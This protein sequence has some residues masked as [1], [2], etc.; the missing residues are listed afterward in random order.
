MSK[1][2][3]CSAVIAE[4]IVR[5]MRSAGESWS[6]FSLF[7]AMCLAM[8]T[9]L[10]GWFITL[11][12]SIE[13]MSIAWPAL[14]ALS[15]FALF[16][17]VLWSRTHSILFGEIG[18]VYMGLALIYTVTP[19]VKFILLNADI[20]ITFDQLGFSVLKP[21]AAELGVHFWRHVLF[22]TAVGLGY[23]LLRGRKPIKCIPQGKTQPG[24]G[25]L[26]PLLLIIIG[27]CIV[28]TVLLS[29][30]VKSYIDHYRRYDQLSGL[31]LFLVHACLLVKSGL[32]FVLFP[33]LFLQY[34][35]YKRL[36]FV[37]VPLVSIYEIIYSHGARIM[38]GVL[39]IACIVLYSFRVKAFGI[40]RGLILFFLAVF[41][42]WL[43]GQ[44]RMLNPLNDGFGKVWAKMKKDVFPNTSPKSLVT[45]DVEH[46]QNL[47]F[48]RFGQGVYF[49][50]AFRGDWV[51]IASEGRRVAVTDIDGDEI[52]DPILIGG[53]GNEIF[54]YYSSVKR[55]VRM[56]KGASDIATGDINGDGRADLLASFPGKGVFSC[57]PVTGTWTRIAS[58][59]VRL[60]A[61]DIDGDGI[62]DLIGIW[63]DQNGVFVRYSGTGKWERIASAAMDVAAGDVDCDGR[64]DIVATWPD[65]GV[66]YRKAKEGAWVRLASY[67]STVAVGLWDGD[68]L[69]DLVAVY[70]RLGKICILK[71]TTQAWSHMSL[72][73][74]DI[75]FGRLRKSPWLSIQKE[76]E[77]LWEHAAFDSVVGQHYDL[78]FRD[79][80][81]AHE[82]VIKLAS[83]NFLHRIGKHDLQPAQGLAVPPDHLV[84]NG[85]KSK[86]KVVPRLYFGEEDSVFCSGFHLY[87]ERNLSRLPPRQW[88]LH[89]DDIF[90]PVPFIDH[91]THN[92]I[93][94]YARHYFPDRVVPP[95]TFGVIA[96]SAVLGGEWDL[97]LRGLLNGILF[98]LVTAWFSN[99][100]K[101][102]WALIVY[103]FMHVTAI[104]VLKYS[105]F[106]Q[107]APLIRS[108]LPA[109]L[110]V[111]LVFKQQKMVLKE[112]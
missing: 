82:D 95:T 53:E 2:D 92:P 67:A 105:V 96:Q 108:I 10:S 25:I 22:M 7:W 68:A 29:A 32:Y 65:Q 48:C 109:I 3:T 62:S 74:D 72:V 93:Y 100:Q 76:A 83:L 60:A 4:W 40:K 8:L 112:K 64:P 91:I 86:I 101:K 80:F 39:I 19:A 11:F 28:L 12:L 111:F 26:I 13:L 85:M 35:R 94:W 45:K 14:A 52:D 97:L 5:C 31:L 88:R 20:P 44:V 36:L 61:D 49:L 106:Y 104:M 6:R 107:L 23:V 21:T 63:P 42:F 102:W 98:A 71:S 58:A 43:V 54:T 18:F 47:I 37:L 78:S 77:M 24:Y 33:L 66:F 103:V 87:H 57:C 38:S 16:S 46:R 81:K 70:P 51:K 9:L 1:L 34:Q 56:A 75:A 90:A 110:L 73:A 55:W 15:C 99:R 50:D 84:L 69:E 59:A 30:P 79:P 27:L 89:V 17:L 41:G